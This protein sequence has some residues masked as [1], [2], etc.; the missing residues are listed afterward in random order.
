MLFVDNYDSFVFNLVQYVR[1]LGA[2]AQVVRND[3]VTVEELVEAIEAGD[4]T[5]VVLSPGPGAPADAGISIDVVRR[6]GPTTPLL[7]VCLGH[8]AIAEAYGGRV[9]RAAEVVHGKPSLVHHDGLGV[10]AG[11]PSP[12]TVAR[13]HSLVADEASL[14]PEL[15]V[16][17]HTASGV[18][19]GLRHTSH[20][21]EGVQWHPESI[22][23]ARGHDLLA[24]FLAAHRP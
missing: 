19:M 17:S 15:V 23:T 9:V 24:A 3:A 7:G 18:V 14:P 13:Y 8:Q 21:V 20:P 2:D 11:L 5:H 6:L 4:L 12:L 22:L 16:T 1:E 10:H